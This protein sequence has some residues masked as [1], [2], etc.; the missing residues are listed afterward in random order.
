MDNFYLNAKYKKQTMSVVPYKENYNDEQVEADLKLEILYNQ[1]TD[2]DLKL[3]TLKSIHTYN[4]ISKRLWNEKDIN[5][6]YYMGR[7][8]VCQ[9]RPTKNQLFDLSS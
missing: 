6:D 1:Q 9:L 5:E 7:S 3:K 4:L 8:G 2:L